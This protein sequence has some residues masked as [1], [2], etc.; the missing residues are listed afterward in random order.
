MYDDE[1]YQRAK[2][3]VE[4][5]RG[6]YGHA[7]AFILVNGFLLILNLL[8]SPSVLWFH[9]SV[10]GW[11]IGLAAHALGVFGAG[12]RFGRDWEERK[13]RE[14]LAPP[15]ADRTPSPADRA[16]PDLTN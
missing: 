3:R 11:G 2:T 15:L 10:L 14:L 7:G 9:W 13:I 6:F 8:T 5:I 1:R 4:E 12:A 16:W